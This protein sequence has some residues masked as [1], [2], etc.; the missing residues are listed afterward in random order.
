MVNLLTS[1]TPYIANFGYLIVAGFIIIEGIG[2]PLPGETVLVFVA[3]FTTT[4]KPSLALV[5]VVGAISAMLADTLGFTLGQRYGIAV[6]NRF[7]R[8]N[9]DAL[10]RSRAFFAKHG[11]KAVF[12]A[13]FIPVVRVF[14]AVLAGTGGIPYRAFITYSALGAWTWATIMSLLGYLF[15]NNLPLLDKIIQRIS[16]SLLLALVIISGGIWLGRRWSQQE[17]LWRQRLSAFASR[18]YLIALMDWMKRRFNPAE[19]ATFTVTTGFIFALGGSWLFGGITQDVL[20]REEFALYDTIVSRWMLA[21]SGAESQA[22]YLAV[23]NLATP[24]LIIVGTAFVGGWLIYKKQ[25][26]QFLA[27]LLALGGGSLLN[28]L[29]EQI[30]KRLPPNIPGALIP[31][32]GYS[33][34]ADQAIQSALFYGTIAYLLIRHGFNWR[35]QVSIAFA[36]ATIVVLVG[37]SQLALGTHY[38]TDVV[39][40]WAVGA[41]WLAAVILA[42]ELIRPSHLPEFV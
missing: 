14:A 22:F 12:L 20:A 36:A 35:W 1:L 39:G 18:L 5:I 24:V 4:G 37:L 40:G 17:L 41:A 29:L 11:V 3:A 32:A 27:L 23:H 25:F 19:R 2:V 33:Y 15:G 21:H 42:S 13:R 38:M 8:G 10:A 26:R 30:V 31:G 16:L 7:H 9:G 34:P 6:I 28:N